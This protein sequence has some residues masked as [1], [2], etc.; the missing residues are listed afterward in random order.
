MAFRSRFTTQ[1]QADWLTPK[2][3]GH[4]RAKPG[5]PGNVDPAVL[6]ARLICAPHAITGTDAQ[7]QA[8][9]SRALLTV[10]S[11]L[12]AQIKTRSAQLDQQLHAHTD[13]HIYTAC[14]DPPE[15]RRACWF[16]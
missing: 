1:D 16:P 11:T 7:S 8:H 9:V 4:W 6:D 3:L 13:A 5:Y 15:G 10:V 2:L 14:P 12:V